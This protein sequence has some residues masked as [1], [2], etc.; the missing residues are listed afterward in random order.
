MYGELI[1]ITGAMLLV[2][3]LLGLGAEKIGLP[4]VTGYLVAG[5]F[6]NPR[7]FSYI[8][9]AFPVHTEP[10]ID[11]CLAFITFEVGFNLS[12]SKIKRHDTKLL[13]VSFLESFG[14]F[15]VVL[16][17]FLFIAPYL[18]NDIPTDNFIALS[19]PFS[20]LLAALASPTDP[21]A[22]L[23]VMHQYKA[24]GPVSDTILGCAAFDDAFT[25]IIYSICFTLASMFMGDS[26]VSF[27]N[28]FSNGILSIAGAV[29]VGVAIGFIFNF[30]TQR[31]AISS[32]GQLLVLLLAAISLAFGVSSLFAF[33]ELLSTLGVGVVAANFNLQRRLLKEVVERYTEELIFI[34]F[35]VVSTMH[36]EYSSLASYWHYILLFVLLRAIGKYVGAFAG[37]SI[38][39][40]DK[41]SRRYTFAGLLPQGGIV[42]GLALMMQKD[43]RF[44]AFSAILVSTIMGA[45]IIHEFAGPVAARWGL[46][47]AGEVTLDNTKINVI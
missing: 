30:L 24:K 21:S 20:L 26:A 10:I 9:E 29:A 32:E 13:T 37:L 14:A 33:D 43:P 23:A 25:L 45:T 2:G 8:P 17:G 44:D 12:V 40:A 42:M 22:T 16:L 46:V 6:L 28:V 39:K 34:F 35:F 15:L 4:K 3:F 11:L 27:G 18:I 36:L 7:L 41:L 31:L 1:L 5:L 38:T 47:K 19:I